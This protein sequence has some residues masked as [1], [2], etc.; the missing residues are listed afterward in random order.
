MGKYL[1][2]ITGASGALYGI[3]A[4]KAL[5]EG[6]HEVHGIVSHWGNQVIMEETG[7]A[8]GSW[9]G[10]LG[11]PPERVYAP[12]DFSSPPAS[13][14]FRLDGTVVAPC[15]M[16][17]IGAI[18]SGVCLN[19]IHRAA[20]TSLKEGR[21]LVLVPRETPFSLP[22]LRNLTALAEV[23]AAILPA[24]PAFYHTPQT[25]EDMIDFVVGKILD[26]LLVEHNLYTRWRSSK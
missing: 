11:L 15:S 14:S 18:A 1:V 26:R 20:L 9:M 10:E 17:S 22:D 4:I 7:K 6:G 2:C 8:F 16:S 5:V 24:S 25:I 12:D 19:L 13:G 3:R 21:P 23:G